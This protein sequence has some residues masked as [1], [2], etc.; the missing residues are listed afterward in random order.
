MANMITIES[1][2]GFHFDAY[3]AKP[4][5]EPKASLV[6]LQEIFGL[7][8]H[9][10]SIADFFASQGY[11]VI[12]PATQHR[13][14]KNLSLG[15]SPED[16]AQGIQHKAVVTSLPNNPVMMDIQASIE[17]VST[18][19]KVGVIGYCWGGFLAWKSACEL[20]G[21]SAAV[22]YYPGGIETT[23][24]LTPSCPTMLHFA[25][26]DKHISLEIVETFKHKQ[27]QS[28]VFTYD[29]QHGFNCDVR[30]AYNA[31][32][33]NLALQRSLSFFKKNLLK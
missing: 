7:N 4:A 30:S 31:N 15:Y 17:Y 33:A 28:E 32:A 5:G 11:L 23:D 26:D 21:L 13:S 18:A 14:V 1:R 20:K 8:K 3:L 2:D 27:A 6:V 24:E 25:N 29:G 19:G 16:M 9:I 12:A 22:S 10:Q